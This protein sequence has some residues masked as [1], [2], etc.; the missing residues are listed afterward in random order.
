MVKIL[1][2]SIAVMVLLNNAMAQQPFSIPSGEILLPHQQ[3]LEQTCG[4][5]PT[6]Q[7]ID[8][9]ENNPDFQERLRYFTQNY[10]QRALQP[11]NYVPIKAH[12]VR[13]SGGTGGLT[14]AQLNSAITNMNNYYL[15]ANMQ[16]YL[17]DGINYIDNNTY[18]DYNQN[19]ETALHGAHGVNNLINIYF[20]N[21]VTSSGGGSLCGY[22]YFPG[23][24]DLIMMAN[25]C[26]INGSTLPHEMGHFFSLYHTHG[27]ANGTLTDELVNGTGCATTGDRVCDTPADPQLGFAN[28]SA[29]CAYNGTAPYTGG[30]ATDANGDPFVP[31]PNNIMSYSRKACRNFFSPGQYA[32]IYAAYTTQRNY[33]T[34]P[35]FNVDFTATPTESCSAPVTV[36]F[37]DNSI[38]ATSWQWDVDGDNVVDYTTQN[39]SHTYTTDG[40]YDVRLTI[41]NGTETI[42]RTKTTYINV[43]AVGNMPYTE[44]FETFTV[45]NNATGLMNNWITTPNNTTADFRWR[46]HNGGTVS[47]NT[48]PVVDNTLGT[49]AGIYM[50]TEASQ[51]ATGD[52]AELISP[53]ISI[54]GAAPILSF[55]YHMHGA[56]TGT[57]HLD[58]YVSGAWVN[59]IMP[60][61]SG[62][63]H[64]NQ[65]DA[66]TNHQVNLAAYTGQTIKIRFRVERGGNFQG[67]VAI[68]DINI[69]AGPEISFGSP[70]STQ[71]ESN[72]SG[73]SGCRGYID[74]NVPVQ[75]SEAPTGDAVVTFT[76]SGTTNNYDYQVL[77][78]SVTFLNGNS[79]AQNVQVRVWDDANEENDETLVLSYTISGTT[80]ASAGTTNQTHTMTVQDND[81]L[82]TD[83]GGA[84]VAT[85]LATRQ[86]YFG[87]NETV[88]FYD[89]SGN[90]M[91]MLQNTSAWDYGCTTVEIDRAG[92]GAIPYDNNTAT[93]YA[94][95]KTYEVTPA[96]NSP[97]GQ[98]NITLYYSGTEISTWEAAS[99]NT[100][101]NL[102]VRKTG[103]PSSN[104]TPATPTGNGATNYNG[105]GTARAVY[106]ASD[107]TVTSTFATG[108]S[109][110]VVGQEPSV[111]LENALVSFEGS[112]LEAQRNQLEWEISPQFEGLRF[113]VERSLDGIAFDK[114]A[115]V[116]PTSSTSY[117]YDWD[118]VAIETR[119]LCY[120]RLK[121][122]DIDGVVVYS[123]I[124]SIAGNNEPIK[125]FDVFPNP[126]NGIFKVFFESAVVTRAK[127]EVYNSV[128]QLIRQTAVGVQ[129]GNNNTIVDLTDL[130]QGVYLLKVAY[131]GN[132]YQKAIVKQ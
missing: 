13:T 66:Y 52:V 20:C 44:D 31:N 77:T 48:G 27:T 38:G 4:F 91:A 33:F 109:G 82:P 3:H 86:L 83:G 81:L 17:C 95:Q 114:V 10:H 123:N 125:H 8:A 5:Q 124:I 98:Y 74:V 60:A 12:I 119:K 88:Y 103:G 28:V 90:V 37:T 67:D 26:T 102:I 35:T 122:M 121:I 59:D 131:E 79:T 73:T 104:I 47:P 32:R 56:G 127:I 61:I 18:Y 120:Y 110:F 16:F 42:F 99:G 21:T 65:N 106:A 41:S 39:P 51:G 30:V 24:P 58:A 111:L 108:F 107:Y 36:N 6:Q 1:L 132:Q 7:Q 46:V 57:L 94:A 49:A 25:S 11:I 75:I 63:Q 15:N 69:S 2:L 55:A 118:D 9:L 80:N 19:D 93:Y 129:I 112:K 34:C 100:R 50:Y 53:C 113:E 128:G 72:T 84:A 70:T 62:Q 97:T 117:L 105:S 87:P 85:A 89:G 22:A 116:L 130:P 115:T 71:A 29:A 45:A 101:T 14:V 68:D 64:V 23:G 78:P 126:S 76:A 96:N 54:T 43:G 40:S 92:T